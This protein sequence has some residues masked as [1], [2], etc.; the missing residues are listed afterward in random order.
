MGR[1]PRRQSQSAG[2]SR[3]LPQ[4]D[5]I[6]SLAGAWVAGRAGGWVGEKYYKIGSEVGDFQFKASGFKVV[7]Q[8]VSHFVQNKGIGSGVC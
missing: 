5:L 4:S 3:N 2:P 8:Q 1:Y 7:F 6:A